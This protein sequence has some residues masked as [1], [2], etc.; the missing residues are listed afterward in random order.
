MRRL[1]CH[2][3]GR[4]GRCQ[5]GRYRRHDHDRGALGHRDDLRA[6]A[7]QPRA[8]PADR[9]CRRVDWHIGI[10]GRCRHCRRA[11]LWRLRRQGAGHHRHGGAGAAV[12]HAHQGRRPRRLDRH[13]GRGT[14][15]RRHHALGDAGRRQPSGRERDLAPFPQIRTRFFFAS[16]LI[17]A[18]TASYSLADYNKVA[19][20]GLI[21]PVKDLRTWCFIFCFFSIGLTTRFRDLASAGRKPF[22]AF[23]VG[24][25]VNV[26]LGFILS[27]HVFGAH[28]ERLGQ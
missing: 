28:W 19:T 9:H 2:C 16:A 6:A 5:E 18:A 7:C 20:P 17:T 14:R 27:V 23:T 11:D 10:R 1:G 21:A 25:V 8:A 15:H 12:L 13:L 24:V 22:T 4:R 26:I 3:R